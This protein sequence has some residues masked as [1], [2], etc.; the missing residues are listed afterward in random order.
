MDWKSVNLFRISIIGNEGGLNTM[1]RFSVSF[2]AIAI[3]AL[4]ASHNPAATAG[5]FQLDP[6]HSDAQ[7]ITDATTDYGKTKLNVTL[8]FARMNGRVEINNDD[9]SKSSFDFRL[10]PSTG[11][12]PV[13]T[14]DGKFLRH[15]LENM[16]NHTLVCF[17]SK[18]AVRTPDGKLQTTG[19]LI[20]TRVDRTVEANPNEAYAGPVYG[21]PVVHRVSHEA[22]FVFDLTP[23]AGK[24][25]VIQLNGKTSTF[26]EDYPQLVRAVLNT[27][28]PP[29]IEDEKCEYPA[30]VGEDYHGANCTGHLLTAPGLPEAPR[31][32]N[33]ED[34]GTPSDFNSIVGNHLNIAV[35]MRLMPAGSGEAA[36][37]Y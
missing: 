9:L 32:A 22:T 15:W 19:T 13:V 4:G 29:V 14:E 25:G 34:I 21:P 28:W 18:G 35:H 6:D 17:H 33:A 20:V 24:G 31:A 2:A 36:G 3:L 27:Y 26:R 5:S 11:M 37:G 1:S 30:T 12:T 10:F 23:A 16:S 7:L 8:G